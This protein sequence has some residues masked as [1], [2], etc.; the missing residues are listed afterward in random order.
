MRTQIAHYSGNHTWGMSLNNGVKN[1]RAQAIITPIVNPDNPVFAP[2]SW[3]TADLEN[4]PVKQSDTDKINRKTSNQFSR[5][6]L[7]SILL[8]LDKKGSIALEV[9][10]WRKVK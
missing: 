6:F 8:E 10:K 1:I 4:D 3:F 9:Y 5:I 7:S 2:L